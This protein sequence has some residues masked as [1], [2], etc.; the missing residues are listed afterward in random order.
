MYQRRGSRNFENLYST[1][2]LEVSVEVACTFL[3][4]QVR[5]EIEQLMDDDSDMAEIPVD[6]ASISA[7][8]TPVSPPP[9]FRRLDVNS[10][11]TRSGHE[12]MRSNESN[13]KN[14]EERTKQLKEYIDDMEHQHST[15]VLC[16]PSFSYESPKVILLLVALTLN[17]KGKLLFPLIVEFRAPSWLL[18]AP[19]S[20]GGSF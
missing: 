17:L 15:G 18:L 9:D 8:I 20:D 7:P 19:T 16:F 4:T 10:S 12:S 6:G 5:V 3:D 14:I 2:S 11:I 1:T 13:T